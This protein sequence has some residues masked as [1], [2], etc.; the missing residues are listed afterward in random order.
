MMK[1]IIFAFI[2]FGATL[3]FVCAQEPEG[4]AT[5]FIEISTSNAAMS[6]QDN[7]VTVS[8]DLSNGEGI[9]SGVKYGIQLSKDGYLIDE[10]VYDEVLS[11][12]ENETVTKE[13]EYLAPDFLAGDYVLDVVV[14][15]KAGIFLSIE[16]VGVVSLF[17][18]DNYID[19][20]NASCFLNVDDGDDE[21]SIDEGVDVS[22]EETLV[23]N[24]DISTRLL[25]EKYFVPIFETYRRS[26]FG[27]KVYVIGAG[28]NGVE[29]I[30]A[31]GKKQVSFVIPKP[32]V[33]QAYDVNIFLADANDYSQKLSNSVFVHYVLRGASATIQNV[34]LDKDSYSK[35]DTALVS[36]YWSPSADNFLGSRASMGTALNDV[37]IE[38]IIEGCSDKF[39]HVVSDS[40]S[41]NWFVNIDVP[42]TKKCINP[43]VKLVIK[44][45]AGILDDS[46]FNVK[47][48][49]KSA[50]SLLA[51]M[52]ILIILT[53]VVIFGL[54]RRKKDVMPLA[55]F[56]IFAVSAFCFLPNEKVEAFSASFSAPKSGGAFGT[57][58]IT[59]TYSGNMNGGSVYVQHHSHS[60]EWEGA[61]KIDS[62]IKV[63]HDN[64]NVGVLALGNSA[65]GYYGNNSWVTFAKNTQPGTHTVRLDFY[66]GRLLHLYDCY[67]PVNCSTDIP[68]VTKCSSL[69]TYDKNSCAYDGSTGTYC[70]GYSRKSGSPSECSYC[71]WNP[72]KF[73]AAVTVG[74]WCMKYTYTKVGSKT[75]SYTV[76][77]KTPTCTLTANPSSITAPGSSTFTL[78]STNATSATYSCVKSGSG[79]LGGTVNGSFNLSFSESQ[80]GT[81]RCTVTVENSSGTPGTCQATLN[82]KPPAVKK[83]SCTISVSPTSLYPGDT[84]NFSWSSKNATQAKYN[85]SGTLS[86]L[87]GQGNWGLDLNK[88]NLPVTIP[89]NSTTGPG[90]CTLTVQNSAGDQATCDASLTVLKKNQ[91]T[92][93]ECGFS[94]GGT[95]STKPTTGLC[96][97][98]NPTT[99]TG[100]GP[101]YWTCTGL[102]GGT[103]DSCSASK[104]SSGLSCS[105]SFSPSSINSGDRSTWSWSSSGATSAYYSCSNYSCSSGYCTYNG[106]GQ[107]GSLSGGEISSG[108]RAE[109]YNS[110]GTNYGRSCQITF[111]D[112]GGNTKTCTASLA[113]T[114]GN[115]CTVDIKAKK[116]G[117]GTYSDGPINI[118]FNTRANL[119]WNSSDT[120]SCVASE[121]SSDWQGSKT[122]TGTYITDQ[123]ISPPNSYTYNLTCS[124][125]GK[126]C[127]DNVVV[128]VGGAEYGCTGAD[129][130]DSDGVRC[131]GD[132]SGLVE[133]MPWMLQGDSASFCTDARKCEY[134]IPTPTYSCTGSIPSDKTQCTDTIVSDLPVE[135]AWHNVATCSVN[136]ECEYHDPVSPSCTGTPPNQST[137]TVCANDTTGLTENWPWIQV[138]SIDDCTNKKCEYYSND[139]V[140]VCG[141]GRVGG[142][143]ECDPPNGT[144]CDS[145][146]N[147]IGG[148]DDISALNLRVSAGDYCSLASHNFLW[149]YIDSS[150]NT[151]TQAGYS[152]QVDNNSDF[153]SP[154]IN[155]TF[156][157]PALSQTA[158][159]S[160]IAKSNQLSYNTTYYWRVK[161]W[162]TSGEYSDWTTGPSFSTKKHKF[163]TS[164]FSY[165]PETP[166]VKENVYFTDKSLCYDESNIAKPE[167]CVSWKWSFWEEQTAGAEDYE[168]GGVEYQEETTLNSQNPIVQFL[169]DL[170]YKV[171]LQ[172]TDG[173]GYVCP[174]NEFDPATID[175]PVIG[176]KKGLPTW[177]EIFPWF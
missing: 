18:T 131:P 27:D 143:E 39:F 169:N 176:V 17:G 153:S 88:T 134:Y 137:H 33:P 90:S 168:E 81:E 71:A 172:V 167:N 4:Q 15:N 86:F 73:P 93:G 29:S 79:N 156:E 103:T 101:W 69:T 159:V 16:E 44:S 114:D 50:Y 48:A 105:S 107:S 163:P 85:C 104:S 61:Q 5:S 120:D 122:L 115:T 109:I 13:V 6:Y 47:S 32:D 63:Y 140:N 41:N 98:G 35:G 121:G 129:P 7:I 55:L 60:P 132:D 19:L 146:C 51:I 110:G 118:D 40:A 174:P 53:A 102:N 151:N 76:A 95:F 108:S 165:S 84:A 145:S 111:S 72:T 42:I 14:K 78:S 30:D 130:E 68:W 22:P 8:F 89:S 26:T 70:T 157:T 147:L 154:E 64:S 2:V 54:G 58:P 125:N 75:F 66:A 83:P 106:S 3:G 124:K 112:N 65:G 142:T 166:S 59:F 91:V 80:T 12:S 116:P 149:G 36:F 77:E 1:K 11:M 113:V 96:T 144:T 136:G 170:N 155:R 173:A 162:D 94:D 43:E 31:D 141:D 82:I 37:V 62:A 28:L 161:V 74:A 126:T 175:S 139:S 127:S 160:P 97:K 45:G 57:F 164:D 87:P 21:Y 38:G 138:S 123:L 135:T 133:N 67:T 150:G 128:N 171:V 34:Q 10:K 20:D 100:N 92:D 152:F 148:G 9:Q 52:I 119:W 56:F 46:V 24:C 23:L 25:E 49:S 117:E 158:I 177:K 99:V